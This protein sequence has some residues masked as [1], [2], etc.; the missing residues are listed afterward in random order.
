MPLVVFPS[1]CVGHWDPKAEGP[2]SKFGKAGRFF[3]WVKQ[4]A[5]PSIFLRCGQF[6]ACFLIRAEF[7]GAGRCRYLLLAESGL[8]KLSASDP[9]SSL[10]VV[11]N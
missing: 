11:I 1:I 5:G 3:Q 2:S 6:C 7:K 9:K 8:P 4:N 10:P